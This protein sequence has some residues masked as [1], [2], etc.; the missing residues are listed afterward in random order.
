MCDAEGNN[1]RLLR[2]SF[3]TQKYWQNANFK[4]LIIHSSARFSERVTSSVGGKDTLNRSQCYADDITG[5]MKFIQR[6]IY[7]IGIIYNIFPE[8]LPVEIVLIYNLT[9]KRLG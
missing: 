9:H 5:E 1:L 6:K 2:E 4:R 8:T 7:K 3:G